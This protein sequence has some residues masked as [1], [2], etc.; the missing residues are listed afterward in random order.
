MLGNATVESIC[1]GSDVGGMS[2][3]KHRE[4]LKERFKIFTKYYGFIP[5]IFNHVFIACN[6]AIYFI[7]HRRTND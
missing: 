6:L 5:N 2:K 7:K 3:K 4:S 1:M